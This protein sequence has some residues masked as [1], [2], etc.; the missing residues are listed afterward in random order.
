MPPSSPQPTFYFSLSIAETPSF[1]EIAFQ[2][3]SGLS[4]ETSIQEIAEGGE[5]GFKHKFPGGSK[6]QNLV[7]KRG[8]APSHSP[9][10]RWCS[11]TLGG[12]LSDTIS[13]KI[14]SLTLKDSASNTLK[15]WHFQNAWP[16]KW[17]VSD[18]MA[19]AGETVIETIEFSY[20]YFTLS[21]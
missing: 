18:L 5:N 16:V 1:P 7:V 4:T 11:E 15:T 10:M 19:K 3:V 6:Y 20:S 8:I 17:D 13:T 21:E 2:E 14:I 9:F 12:G